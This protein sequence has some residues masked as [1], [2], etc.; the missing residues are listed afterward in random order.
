[1]TEF[2]KMHVTVNR[3]P[4]Y[5]TNPRVTLYLWSFTPFYLCWLHPHPGELFTAPMYAKNLSHRYQFSAARYAEETIRRKQE[6]KKKW[7]VIGG[8]PYLLATPR[9]IKYQRAWS[10]DKPLGTQ[11]QWKGWI[12]NF[13]KNLIRRPW[14][15]RRRQRDGEHRDY[16][17]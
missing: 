5:P 8:P 9:Q 6:G 12:E 2:W 13:P 16:I 11:I 14:E 10:C 1:M 7:I 3:A 4:R 17:N 15:R